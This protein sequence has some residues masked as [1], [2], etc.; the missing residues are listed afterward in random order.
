MHSPTAAIAQFSLFIYPQLTL[1]NNNKFPE[2][3]Y[4]SPSSIPLQIYSATDTE[5]TAN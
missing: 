1:I 4:Q 5:C 2:L 3:S